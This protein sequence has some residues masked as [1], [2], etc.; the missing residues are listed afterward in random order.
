MLD[1]SEQ[2]VLRSRPNRERMIRNCDAPRREREERYIAMAMAVLERS[3]LDKRTSCQMPVLYITLRRAPGTSPYVG[4][5]A[6]IKAFLQAIEPNLERNGK[7]FVMTG[8]RPRDFDHPFH[9]R[10]IIAR[11]QGVEA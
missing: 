4:R 9:I 10:R 7:E 2:V 8:N 11:E 6:M 3:K 1:R 5:I